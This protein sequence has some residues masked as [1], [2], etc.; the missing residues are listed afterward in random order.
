MSRFSTV[1]KTFNKVTHVIFDLDGLLLDTE[2]IYTEATNNVVRQF[3]KQ[4]T[5]DI[6]CQIMGLTGEE[7]A[8]QI[9]KLLDL[10]ITWEEYYRLAHEQYRLLMPHAKFMSGAKDLVKHLHKSQIP[11]AVATSST[12]DSANL[13]TA[14]YKDIFSLF[15]HIVTGGSDPE[16]K[17]GKPSPEIFLVCASRFPDLPLPEKCLVFEDAPNG[18]TAAISAGMQCVMVP[19]SHIPTSKTT[20]ATLVL[21]SLEDL[22]LEAF[23][24]PPLH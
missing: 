6:K 11:I 21:K 18:V 3:G 23:G 8:K 13:K 20:H 1:T 24:L 7:A 22:K 10:P 9:V 16:V 4:F 14:K 15:N 17:N 2:S 19:D 5:W 12:E